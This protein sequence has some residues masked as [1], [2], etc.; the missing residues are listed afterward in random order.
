MSEKKNFLNFLKKI[1]FS[2]KTAPPLTKEEEE[3]IL[4]NLNQR[5][6]IIGIVEIYTD[7]DGF[8]ERG[9]NLV[10]YNGRE[11]AASKTFDLGNYTDW[12]ITHFGVGNGGTSS[13]SSTIK[14]GPNDNDTDLYSPLTLN[15]SDSTYLRNGI[16][17]PINSKTL[18]LDQNTNHYTTVENILRIVVA[19]E[20]DLK[21]PVKINEAALF[22]TNSNGD[23][24]IFSH[25]TTTDKILEENESITFK[26]YILF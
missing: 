3:F 4:E 6:K 12:K 23:W 24:R 17:K 9:N 5:D 10:V 1:K 21:S 20:P 22:Y 2:G 14:I 19:N 25:Y 11:F 7:K 18:I 13:S 8:I 26:W 16:L 15:S